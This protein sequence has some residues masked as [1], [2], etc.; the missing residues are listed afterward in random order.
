MNMNE[1]PVRGSKR[2]R[3][4]RSHVGWG[5]GNCGH[6]WLLKHIWRKSGSR[7]KLSDTKEFDHLHII[8]VGYTTQLS[9]KLS[10]PTCVN[11]GCPIT[12]APPENMGGFTPPT[13]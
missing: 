12:A 11:G 10:V 1:Y 6:G 13:S 4:L 3:Q 2:I 8:P 7:Q 9:G 5:V